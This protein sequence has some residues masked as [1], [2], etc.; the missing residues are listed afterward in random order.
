MNI[1]IREI[2]SGGLTYEDQ[3][4]PVDLGLTEEFID[5]EKPIK[6]KGRL[7]RVDEFVLVK[8]DVTYTAD[9]VCARCLEVRHG[10]VTSHYEFE[11]EFKPGDEFVNL[12][13]R[14]REEILMGHPS[15][16]LCREDCKGIC[17]GCGAYLNEEECQCDK[18][19]K[20]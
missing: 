3:V 16:S 1:K 13:E 17:P 11:I 18:K 6:V 4:K 8:I 15:R 19:K 20:E 12:G 5:L 9:T 14:I 2:L 10:E 7:E